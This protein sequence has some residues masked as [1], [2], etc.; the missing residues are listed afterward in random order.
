MLLGVF[1][2]V[3]ETVWTAA[4]HP[5]CTCVAIRAE[6]ACEDGCARRTR[7]NDTT[8]DTCT[9]A[10]APGSVLA[11]GDARQGQRRHQ[12]GSRHQRSLSG[13]PVHR[14][15]KPSTGCAT[16]L[17]ITITP[18]ET[19]YRLKSLRRQE[20][21]RSHLHWRTCHPQMGCSKEAVIFTPQ[22]FSF[23]QTFNT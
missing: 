21:Q 5:A 3:T 15:L 1:V 12:Q 20:R 9:C 23:R 6:R 22:G 7:V 10:W 2:K 4:F 11:L 8:G 17:S 13:C 14:N 18:S 19:F 16:S